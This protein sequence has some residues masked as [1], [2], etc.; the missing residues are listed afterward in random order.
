MAETKEE[1]VQ[2]SKKATAEKKKAEKK[3]TKEAAR[4]KKAAEKKEK[5]AAA[6]AQK[7]EI[8][9]IKRMISETENDIKIYK[10]DA[11]KYKREVEINS[12]DLIKRKY[13]SYNDLKEFIDV[14]EKYYDLYTT[15]EEQAE[16]YALIV[17]RGTKYPE[18]STVLNPLC[19]YVSALNQLKIRETE[20]IELNNRLNA[21]QNPETTETE[22]TEIPDLKGHLY[23][24][25]LVVG[26]TNELKFWNKFLEEFL[27]Q[28]DSTDLNINITWLMNKINWVCRKVNY[29]LAVLRY[30][31]IKVLHAIYKQASG[32]LTYIE[33]V[34]TF[35]PTNILNCLDWVKNVIKIF[36]FPYVKIVEFL[37]DFTTYTPPLVAEATKLVALLAIVPPKILSR[38]RLAANDK[39]SG[40]KKALI[41]VYKQYINIE[42]E[43][44]TVPDIIAGASEKPQMAEFTANKEKYNS[45]VAQQE[46]T[47]V[48][49][50]NAW[51]EIVS[52]LQ[53]YN[54]KDGKGSKIRC[55]ILETYIS[56]K[57]AGTLFYMGNG[58][59]KDMT[60]EEIAKIVYEMKDLQAKTTSARQ[61]AQKAYEK[62]DKLAKR[63]QTLAAKHI[64]D[65]KAIAEANEAQAEAERAKKEL[66][67]I[68]ETASIPYGKTFDNNKYEVNA[69]FDALSLSVKAC[70][71]DSEWLGILQVN[72]M[73]YYSLLAQGKETNRSG[74]EAHKYVEFLEQFAPKFKEILPQLKVIEDSYKK[75][76]KIEKDINKLN[77]RSI[78]K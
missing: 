70:S 15:K 17:G 74:K 72:V 4:E 35:K 55:P 1:L 50:K 2:A 14:G 47:E 61:K 44:I 45:Y 52:A 71:D 5:A 65:E 56:S 40:E 37:V 41:D 29:A 9:K 20:L 11:E 67:N 62:A 73:A 22:T 42:M 53:V 51:A 66:A 36:L 23:P 76:I 78:F 16:Y 49:I 58:Y 38:L 10:K 69:Y 46:S 24:V 68:P 25:K 30:E 8:S 77:R 32:F 60:G 75:Y 21:A 3:A 63:N 12:N 28:L 6:S 64:L 18:L 43:P 59:N 54:S 31:I 27:K 26:W 13:I 19:E 7:A 33:P 57:D 34:A 39:E 48:A